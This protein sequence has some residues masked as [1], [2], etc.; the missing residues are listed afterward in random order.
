MNPPRKW[1]NS[2][3]KSKSKSFPFVMLINSQ[4][5]IDS[6]SPKAPVLKMTCLMLS[7]HILQK[8]TQW[9]SRGSAQNISPCYLFD[10]EASS[11][12]D[13]IEASVVYAEVE[14]FVFLASK[15]YLGTM[16][17]GSLVDKS[18]S[19]IVIEEVTENFDHRLG[20]GIHQNNWQRISFF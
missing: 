10:I 13:F 9:C 8:T 14:G 20:E 19:E 12:W 4:N 3:V 2:C 17:G 1:I 7:H 18:G 6:H 11:H 16:G 5:I 15:D